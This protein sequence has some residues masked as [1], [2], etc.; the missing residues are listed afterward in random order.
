EGRRPCALHRSCSMT[1]QDHATALAAPDAAVF[2]DAS[3]DDTAAAPN[4]QPAPALPDRAGTAADASPGFSLTPPTA[5]MS[6]QV[7]KRNGAR[8]PVDLNKIVRAISRCS[9]DLYAVDPMRVATRTISGLYDGAS[10]S[11]L[12]ER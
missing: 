11:A 1:Q 9:E 8:E 3:V 6:M 7:T 4:A 12:D 10:T 2:V 5:A